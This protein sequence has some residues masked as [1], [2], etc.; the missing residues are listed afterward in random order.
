MSKKYVIEDTSRLTIKDI[1]ALYNEEVKVA[2]LALDEDDI[3]KTKSLPEEEYYIE[4]LNK[5]IYTLIQLIVYSNK[6]DKKENTDAY[7]SIFNKCVK[8]QKVKKL[9][10]EKSYVYEAFIGSNIHYYKELIDFDGYSL[11]SINLKPAMCDYLKYK[12]A[13]LIQKQQMNRYKDN[14]DKCLEEIKILEK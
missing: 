13:L 6:Y 8:V 3:N 10:I 9:N 1:E 7:L 4:G 5:D 14:F 12:L 11:N 2:C